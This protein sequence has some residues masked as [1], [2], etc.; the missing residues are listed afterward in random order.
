MINL[1]MF[2]RPWAHEGGEN[3]F[4]LDNVEDKAMLSASFADDSSPEKY[5]KKKHLGR[6]I[7]K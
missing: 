3:L 5:I 7:V 1:G 6:S 2:L 4:S